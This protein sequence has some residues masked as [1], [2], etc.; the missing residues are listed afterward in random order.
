MCGLHQLMITWIAAHAKLG[1][2][3]IRQRELGKT[4]SDEGLDVL[5]M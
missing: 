2:G 4:R 3:C 1:E 5:A